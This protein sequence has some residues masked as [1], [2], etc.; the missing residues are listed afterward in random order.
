MRASPCRFRVL[1]ACE[2][3]LG[4]SWGLEYAAQMA[5]IM[6]FVAPSFTPEEIEEAQIKL[7]YPSPYDQARQAY[8]AM[9]SVY[10]IPIA[11]GDWGACLAKDV[12]RLRPG[13]Q[14]PKRLQRER[15][16]V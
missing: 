5:G 15:Y 12:E 10:E 9:V 2:I 1:Q 8:A 13:L 16:L 6:E 11:R 3:I 4:R 14:L 7:Q